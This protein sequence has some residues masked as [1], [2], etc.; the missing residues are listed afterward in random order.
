MKDWP[1]P[2]A[3]FKKVLTA[4]GSDGASYFALL[5]DEGGRPMYEDGYLTFS[6]TY[7]GKPFK[8]GE[9]PILEP[10]TG[11]SPTADQLATTSTVAK[12]ARSVANTVWDAKLGVAWEA[13]MHDGCL[14]YV[15]ITNEP[16]EVAE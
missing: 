9:W 8:A 4:T 10:V 11:I 7:G 3:P 2:E 6:M 1:D 15:A 12:V 5:I 14:Y 16:P 13:R